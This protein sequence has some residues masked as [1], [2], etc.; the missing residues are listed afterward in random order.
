VD[1]KKQV[2]VKINERLAPI[3][4]KRA[5]IDKDPGMI[6]GLIASG[7]AKAKAAAG[8]TMKNVRKLMKLA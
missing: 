6:T 7:N 5:E 8:E 4:L 2:A 1:C 3:R